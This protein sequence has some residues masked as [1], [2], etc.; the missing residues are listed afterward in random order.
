MSASLIVSLFAFGLDLVHMI[1]HIFNEPVLLKIHGVVWKLLAK[2]F[3]FLIPVFLLIHRRHWLRGL[4]FFCSFSLTPLP[5]FAYSSCQHAR[6]L[7]D[8]SGIA[9]DASENLFGQI[10]LK[11]PYGSFPV[12]M[13]KITWWGDFKPFEFW[14]SPEFQAAWINPR[15]QEVLRQR[16]RG[17]KCRL[18]KTSLQGEKQP[19]GEFEEGIW[20]VVVTCEDYLISKQNFAVLPLQPSPSKT[21]SEESRPASRP[22]ALTIWAKDAVRN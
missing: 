3:C 13:D 9:R 18:A 19:S 11:P 21:Q 17:T 14:Q 4:L 5:V 6:E 20:S 12:D 10:K 1:Y 8:R 22:E 16:F 2:F 7:L 15:G